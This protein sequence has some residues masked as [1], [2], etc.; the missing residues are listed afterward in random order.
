MFDPRVQK[1]KNPP[2]RKKE[3]ARILCFLFSL[4]FLFS[5]KEYR[6]NTL[7]FHNFVI[8]YLFAGKTRKNKIV[9]IAGKQKLLKHLLNL[10]FDKL[11]LV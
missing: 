3:E 1:H 4:S 7:L 6:L 11:H 8:C 9:I 10:L 2:Q 5:A